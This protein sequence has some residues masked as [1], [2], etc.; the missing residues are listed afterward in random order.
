MQQTPVVPG[1]GIRQPDL[2]LWFALATD[3]ADARL[4]G[5]LVPDRVF[6]A[7][8]GKPLLALQVSQAPQEKVGGQVGMESQQHPSSSTG[9]TL[10]TAGS[11]SATW[12]SALGPFE[13]VDHR[14]KRESP[15]RTVRP[16]HAPSPARTAPRAI[17]NPERW[18][19]RQSL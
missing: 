10:L 3:I 17:S 15:L 18:S 12:S 11:G 6:S 1:D 7:Q 16:V 2:T 13:S 4:A 14:R 8:G 19:L 5:T 9:E